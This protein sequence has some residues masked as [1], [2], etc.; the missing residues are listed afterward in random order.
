[1]WLAVGLRPPDGERWY[2]NS[3][4]RS[5]PQGWID[6]S[7]HTLNVVRDLGGQGSLVHASLPPEAKR[8]QQEDQESSVALPP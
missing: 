7:L 3:M 6:G 4:S 5:L 8:A 1:M 2:G